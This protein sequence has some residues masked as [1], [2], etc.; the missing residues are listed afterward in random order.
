MV[1]HRRKRLLESLKKT[2]ENLKWLDENAEQI[3]EKRFKI[4]LNNAQKDQSGNQQQD[5]K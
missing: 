5:K 2:E 4:L 1:E 3:A